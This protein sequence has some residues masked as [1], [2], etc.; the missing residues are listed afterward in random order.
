[1][2]PPHVLVSGESIGG[3]SA[4][5]WLAR[6]GW[7]V[8]VL[9]RAPSFR[10]GGQNVDVRGVGRE[11]LDRMGLFETVKAL[12]TTETGTVLV[13]DDGRVR[14]ELPSDDVDG[15][16]AELEVLRGDLARAV[17]DALPDGV[18]IVHD[19]SIRAVEDHDDHVV[20][21]TQQGRRYEV[22]LLVVAEGVR[23]TTRDLV[24]S[25]VAD[26]HELGITM[27]FGT[28][29][30]TAT[31][32]DTWRWYNAVGGRQVHLRPDPYGTTRAIL[33]Y[34]D[35]GDLAGVGPDEARTSLRE[36]FADAGWEAPRVLDGFDRTDDLY[37]DDLAQVRMPTW[38]RGRV[39]LLG[40]AGWC[41]TPI[42]GGG[43]T[44]ALTAGYVLAA[45]LTHGTERA[46]LERDLEAYEQWLRPVVADVQRLPPGMDH[47]AFPRTRLGLAARRVVDK[48]M[49][50]PPLSRLAARATHVAQTDQE[51]PPLPSPR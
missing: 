6:T 35:G 30:R 44:L 13:G 41:V 19:D 20:V 48:A 8:T 42:G 23:S 29:E 12:N 18:E 7:Q 34:A 16:T 32:D 9:E 5:F 37:V 51:L 33:A 46:D 15:S 3:L 24:F 43:A 50:T 27:A 40:D 2:T 28:I 1:M 21:T 22:A 26:V 4:A 47:F 11:V 14:T 31:D 17:R 49:T 10:D 36:R 45:S 25:D 38:H 39:C